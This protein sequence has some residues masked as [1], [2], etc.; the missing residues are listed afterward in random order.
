MRYILNIDYRI[1]KAW[2]L[3]SGKPLESIS[4]YLKWYGLSDKH[5]KKS[6]KMENRNSTFECD[7]IAV[8]WA[9]SPR[10]RINEKPTVWYM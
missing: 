8:K 6:L 10:R 5:L 2:V 9:T 4:L 1:W 3:F 7:L